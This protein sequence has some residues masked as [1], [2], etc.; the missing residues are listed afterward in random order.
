VF[1]PS[2]IDKTK[3]GTERAKALKEY[4]DNPMAIQL[5]PPKVAFKLLLGL[6]EEQVQE[7]IDAME[8]Y[9]TEQELLERQLEREDQ[10]TQAGAAALEGP[11]E[12]DDMEEEPQ[13]PRRTKKPVGGS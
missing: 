6:N 5:L 13:P 12:D 11:E 8:S 9:L 1:A 10:A 7:A 4:A 3:V 2:E